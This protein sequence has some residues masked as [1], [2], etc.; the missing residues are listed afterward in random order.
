M[1]INIYDYLKDLENSDL[2][3]EHG[4]ILEDE[5]RM[6]KLD[7]LYDSYNN[8]YY[9][10]I[11]DSLFLYVKKLVDM[12]DKTSG[13]LITELLTSRMYEK[14]GVNCIKT[15]PVFDHGIV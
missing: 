1:N 14:N 3:S 2:K 11:D 13:R 6:K 8:N 4:I 9:Y 15:F 12:Y 10:S 7:T 5:S